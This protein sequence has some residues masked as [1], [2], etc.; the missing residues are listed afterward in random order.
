MI[1]FLRKEKFFSVIAIILFILPFF[2]LKPGEMDIGGDS[3]RLYFYDPLSFLKAVA[4]YSVVPWGT[5]V[6]DNNQYLFPY[7]ILL[8]FLKLIFHSPTML[9]AIFNG[10][11]LSGS[12]VFIFLII[13][14]LLGKKELDEKNPNKNI[15]N[16]RLAAIIGGLFYTFSP[17][18]LDNMKY[19]LITH[20]QVFAYPM[21]FYFIL[22]SFTKSSL[23]YVWLALLISVMFSSSFVIFNP[24]LFA[25]F[26]L[27]M[28]FLFAYNSFV[29]RKQIPWKGA[30]IIAL[31]FLG[32]HAFHLIPVASNIFDTGS[33]FNTRVFESAS[34]IN[35][36]LE[37]FNAILPHG[38]VSVSI[39][40][41]LGVPIIS[42]SLLFI[43]LLVVLGFLSVQKKSRTL[44]LVSIFF[45]ITLFLISANITQ[46]GV[47]FYRKLF[48]IPGFGMFRN[49][50]GQWQWVY[51]FFYALL[52][53][54]TIFSLLTRIKTKYSYL[55]LI[56]TIGLLILRSWSVF[57][58]RIVNVANRG[59][60]EVPVVIR[61][62]P[63]YENLLAYIGN[64]SN[65]GKI[66]QVPFTDFGYNLF[67]GANGGVYVGK[68]IMSL[69][70]GRNDFSGYQDIDPFSEV[71]V[72]LSREKNYS[73]IKQMMTLLQIR[74]I[75]YNSDTRISDKFFPTF[76]YG[77]TGV[78]ASPSA[79]LDFV[80]NISDKKIYEKGY[81]SLFEVD[82]EQY[83]PNFYIA[84]NL[85]FYDTNPKYD[86]QYLKAS[87]FFPTSG[88]N[89]NINNK[90]A[91]IDRQ[92]C[93][94]FLKKSICDKNSYDM[95]N[96]DVQ[97]IFQKVNPTKYKVQIENAV[98]PFLL[99]FQNAFSPKWKMYQANSPLD[100]KN[101]SDSYDNEKIIELKP[102][103]KAI[104]PNAFE[105]NFLRREKSSTHLEVNGY[106]NGW[107]VEPNAS[108]KYE[109]IIEMNGQKIFYYSLGVSVVSL[110]LFLVYGL[111]LIRK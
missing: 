77:Y 16:E 34:K 55:L 78:P 24:P 70:V 36:G 67:G 62:D 89:T 9:I 42:W 46:I 19:A 61:M 49:F 1:N 95:I 80:E 99:V 43:P 82:K 5:G 53:G 98:K 107:Y 85:L 58:G 59:S 87:S 71:F 97:I 51:A 18:V 79:A 63:N 2:W 31:F 110:L 102:A 60:E 45:F 101:I 86:T 47:E 21:V 13:K 32:L 6:V 88:E 64:I 17:A 84:S 57:D 30:I 52:I 93:D 83:L 38:K 33:E 111:R 69:I 73:L 94:K 35:V 14:S 103:G 109:I 26:P 27:A 40:M 28:I 100:V 23:K 81:Y 48:L 22:L 50:S 8:V 4:I 11:K 108:G 74:Y 20:D 29:L 41:P 72:K 56:I 44:L 68:S 54:L 90:I 65:G 15:I 12:F 25:F 7:S 39:L 91:Y 66:L 106:A 96:D 104:D 3:S 105:T 92:T 37:Y 10:L 75:L 76:P